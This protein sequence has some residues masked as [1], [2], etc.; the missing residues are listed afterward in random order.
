MHRPGL[1]GCAVGVV[2]LTALLVACT[3]PTTAER[4]VTGSATGAASSS[5]ARADVGSIVPADGAPL[6]SSIASTRE[7]GEPVNGSTPTSTATS[8]TFTAASSP[9]GAPASKISIRT[10]PIDGATGVSPIEPVTVSVPDGTLQM[11]TLTTPEG[12]AVRSELSADR[13]TWGSSEPLG[14]GRTYRLEVTA[15]SSGGKATSVS[16]SFTTL[17]P[18][19][20]IYPSFF[21]NPDMTQV[22]IGQPMVVIFDK[23]PANRAAAERALKVT[24]VP[25]V[26]GSW[27]WTDNRTVHY[28]PETFWKSGTEIT[29]EA[30]V[31]GIDLGEDMYGE[32]DRTLRV[33]VGASKIAEINDATKQMR[34]YVDGR[35]VDT[36]PVSMGM[37]K[38]ITVKGKEIS[39]L[40]PSGTYVV[41]EK[42]RV[43]QMS[44]ASYG[45]PTSYDLGYDKAIPLAVRISNSGIFVHSAPW[46]VADQGIRNVSHGCI[47]INPVAAK[48]FYDN[49][50]YGDIVTVAGTA[51]ALQPDDGFG[52]WNIPWSQWL[53]GSAL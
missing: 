1:A 17:R 25:A 22:G 42:Y 4:S 8:S 36:V 30:K 46:S 23:P 31:Y 15:T 32:T 9:S 10:T 35:L 21:P 11:V 26:R 45:L 43:K 51:S 39:L 53:A 34:V 47:N 18:A 5:V 20:T 48:W 3:A 7:S 27:Y 33:T 14:Y 2:L 13:R 52:D 41:Q 16:L 6:P 19:G 29:V 12:R 37:D 28:R 50:G 49:F 44:S 24:T 38:V 40:T